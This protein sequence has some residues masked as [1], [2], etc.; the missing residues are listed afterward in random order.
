MMD[1]KDIKPENLK[2]KDRLRAFGQRIRHAVGR[3]REL[4]MQRYL[5]HLFLLG[6][7]A[8]GGWAA[9]LGLA[10]R[11]TG[12]QS[13]SESNLSPTS[14]PAIEIADLLGFGGGAIPSAQ[15]SRFVDGH[16]IIPNR[17]RIEVVSY[18]VES[19]DSLF[20]IA[21]NFGL[22]P[23]TLLWGNFSVLEDNPHSLQPGQQLN[24]APVD[25][26][27]HTFSEGES[28]TGIADFFNISV[29]EI[30]DWPGNHL[31]P[32]ID[33]EDPPVVPGTVLMIPGAREFVSW[34][35]PRIPRSNPSVASIYGPG[36]CGTVYDGP[37]GVGAFVWPTN[38]VYLSGYDY[39]PAT[40][41]W[42]IDIGGAVGHGIFSTDAGVVVYSGWHN[43]GYGFVVVL[44]HGNGWQT[45]YAHLSEIFVGC[46]TGVFQGTSIG[47]MGVTGNTTGPHLHFEMLHD[48]YGRVNPWNYLP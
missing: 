18:L 20:G 24:I 37:V 6:L 48:V 25:G 46:G 36:A 27:L 42:G 40:N 21:G 4:P 39:S 45:L 3:V 44:D 8:L 10:S 34:A 31:S 7:I 11:Q 26:T 15:I 14:T 30:I 16:T 35:M 33:L 43:G 17:P 13:E 23:E 22:K 41:H 47:L 12:S 5:G 38:S 29:R 1:D 28:L 32:D 9:R 2:T 19:G